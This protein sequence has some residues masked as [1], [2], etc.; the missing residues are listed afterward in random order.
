ME[1]AD[2]KKK[3]EGALAASYKPVEVCTYPRTNAEGQSWISGRTV[4]GKLN[5]MWNLLACLK[6]LMYLYCI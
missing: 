6:R 1:K 5:E 2:V 3:T 4:L